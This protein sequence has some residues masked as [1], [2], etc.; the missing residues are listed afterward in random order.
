MFAPAKSVSTLWA[1]GDEATRKAIETAHEEAIAETIKYL[2]REA[3]ATRAGRNGVAQ[4]E[5]EG[6][7]IA[8]RFRHYDS[9]N[10]DPQ[11]HDHL[12]VANKVK[13]SDGK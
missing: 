7:I 9:R 11:L 8:T 5:V 2:E 4:I 1:L 10:G 12:V 13:G 3:V 6:G